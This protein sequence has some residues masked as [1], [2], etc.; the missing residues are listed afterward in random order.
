[1]SHRILITGGSGYLGG[2]LLARWKEAHLP[3]YD[4]LFALV[5]TEAQ[6]AAVRQ[7]GAKP[8]TINLSD[9]SSI[10]N[11]IVENNIT[12]IYHLINPVDTTNTVHFITGLAQVK[13]QTSQE[14]HFLFTT[15]AKIFS[16][17]AGA[18]TDKPLLDTDPNLYDIQ[19][20]QVDRA[21]HPIMGQGAKANNIV[22]ETAEAQGVRSYVFAPCIVYGR[23]EGFGNPISIQ[24][25][26]IVKAAKSL[27]QV[28]KV[29]KGRPTWPVCHVIDNTNL[30]LEILSAILSNQEIGYGKKGYYLASPGS[31][32]WDDIYAA[33]GKALKNKDVVTS[34][35]VKEA[36][37]TVMQKMGDALGCA[38]EF[39]PVQLG[40]L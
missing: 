28:Y 1:M 11:T 23:G 18:P 3:P 33:I 30:Y 7:Y 39:V 15:G 14:V 19:K 5:R 20:A 22:V 6:A 32:A 24:T 27:R 16:E 17:H 34:D 35:G 31:V 13:K 38:K 36:D 21:P 40:G 37:A 4:Q 8:I 25:V 12:V 26:A 9:S 29:D 10:I 2:T